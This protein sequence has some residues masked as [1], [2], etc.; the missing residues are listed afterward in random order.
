M[1]IILMSIIIPIFNLM[2]SFKR[3]FLSFVV[4]HISSLRY[5]EFSIKLGGYVFP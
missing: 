5:F 3:A 2:N 1:G 4:F